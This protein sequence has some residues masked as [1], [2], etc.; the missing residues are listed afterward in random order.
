MPDLNLPTLAQ[1]GLMNIVG[2]ESL[3]MQYSQNAV[4]GKSKLKHFGAD[5]FF[6][7]QEMMGS[8]PIKPDTEPFY[9]KIDSVSRHY[10]VQIIESDVLKRLI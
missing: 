10:S 5:T 6:G 4:F 8:A 2:F 7:H 1:L 9:T 3:H